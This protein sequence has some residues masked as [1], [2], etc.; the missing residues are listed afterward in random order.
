MGDPVG[1][2]FARLRA[3]KQAARAATVEGGGG[4]PS[5]AFADLARVLASPLLDDLATVRKRKIHMA[6]VAAL[7]AL[8]KAAVLLPP[9]SPSL[10]SL[11]LISDLASA[12]LRPLL[13]A[14]QSKELDNI[15][16]AF[17]S[18]AA[19]AGSTEASSSTTVASARPR[20]PPISTAREAA[21]AAAAAWWRQAE[22]ARHS[23]RLPLGWEVGA[24]TPPSAMA[25]LRQAPFSIESGTLYEGLFL[26]IPF[27]SRVTPTNVDA[28]LRVVQPY[29]DTTRE[30]CNGSVFSTCIAPPLLAPIDLRHSRAGSS[31]TYTITIAPSTSLNILR[32]AN[33]A[34]TARGDDPVFS[35]VLRAYHRRDAKRIHTWPPGAD[36]AVAVNGHWLETAAAGA[37]ELDLLPH[38]R[39]SNTITIS[40][41]HCTCGYLYTVLAKRTISQRMLAAH[42]VHARPWMDLHAAFGAIMDIFVSSASSGVTQDSLPVA[43]TCP[44]SFTRMTTPVR[45]RA[46][47]H[48]QAYDLESYLAMNGVAN[49]WRCAVCKVDLPVEN[50]AVDPLMRLL[51]DLTADPALAPS[52]NLPAACATTP[53]PGS[54]S[55][56]ASDDDDDD[57]DDDGL[58]DTVYFNAV[59][60][61]F[62]DAACSAPVPVINDHPT[63]V[64]LRSGRPTPTTAPPRPVASLHPAT[65]QPLPP[66]PAAQQPSS[67]HKR[68]A[69]TAAGERP[70]KAAR[71]LSAKPILPDDDAN[72]IVLSSD[73]DDDFC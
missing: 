54:G 43:L 37:A 45:G 27:A 68:P 71:L 66:A 59:G 33:A 12:R 8:A 46:C 11:P 49:Q 21:A 41:Q 4:D 5:S 42:I 9:S 69:G 36:I 56:S 25:K 63:L 29:S 67:S 48:F 58:L 15:A 47:R 65:S 44:L 53:G 28:L 23:P 26:D 1:E 7:Q 35:I 51:L 19:P 61:V 57:D 13:G 14:K 64:A 32:Q 20:P 10:A 55:G 70:T 50:L 3:A 22:E 72:L 6:L 62:A 60:I 40:S 73:D 30:Y 2:V 24:E 34:L 18:V 16:A 17:A 52:L 38:L 39:A 31:A